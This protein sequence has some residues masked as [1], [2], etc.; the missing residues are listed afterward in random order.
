MKS[1][2]FLMLLAAAAVATQAQSLTATEQ[3]IVAEVQRQHAANVELLKETVNINSGSLNIAGVKA[4]GEKLAAAYRKIGF[5]TEWISLPDSL[6]RAGHLVAYRKGKKGKRILMIGHLDT[7]FEPD[8]EA[9]PFRMINDSTATGQGVVDMKGGN[10]MM[11]AIC[12]ALAN[13]NLIDDAT[14]VC[15]YTGDE[16]STGSPEWVSRQDFIARAKASDIALGFETA[17]NFST[18]AIGRRGSS[19]WKLTVQGKQSHSAGMF[20]ANGSYGAI[21]EAA[22]ILTEFRQKLEGEKYL[23][24]S[25]GVI[26]GG[27]ELN[28]NDEA[29]RATVSGKTN[30]IAPATVV[31]GD[32][33]F[34]GEQQK[35]NARNNMRQIVVNNLRGTAAQ[36]EFYDGF[37][38]M[39]PKPGNLQ[40]V[41]Q[42]ND[43]SMAMGLGPVKAGDPGSRG[44]GDISWVAQYVDCIDGLGAS[45]GGAHAPGE[46]INMKELPRLTERAAVL[47]YRLTR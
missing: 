37:P 11:L 15:Y 25:P 38:S 22:R 36:I 7:V 23:T 44:A 43:V 39:E 28:T 5:T 41:Q 21:Y 47:V 14:I 42:L 30:I 35:A 17:Q 34:L 9:N 20:G 32:L 3:K 26:A 27:T 13:L 19:S 31:Y 18:V 12:Q 10:V 16:E 29:F 2:F 24:F 8:M 45:G 33:R 46:I 40:L 6:K 1:F 4:V